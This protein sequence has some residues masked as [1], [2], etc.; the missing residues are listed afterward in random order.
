MIPAL[1]TVF[2]FA[3]SAVAGERTARYW[4]SQTG[5]LLRLGLATLI[6]GSL[7]LWLWPDS[8]DPA[9]YTWLFASGMIGFGFGD[10]A[11]FLA[12]VRIG[13]RLTILLNLC[14][15]PLWSTVVEGLWLGQV[16]GAL[17]LCAGAVIL[18]GVVMAVMSRQAD[19]HQRLGSP[20]V[21][22]ACGLLAGCGQGLGAVLSRKALDVA[23]DTGIVMNGMSAATQRVSGGLLTT[24][25]VFLVLRYLVRSP[26]A[27][28]VPASARVK[29]AW[30]LATTLCGPVL[31]V[32]C[33]QWAW[34][35]Q[36]AGVVTAVVATTPIA[37]IPLVMW[38][39]KEHPRPM[40]VAG[41]VIAVAGVLMLLKA[42][43]QW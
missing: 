41:A 34:A 17:E 13:A 27:P 10:I 31:G 38:A 16:P 28:V 20:I 23:A 30:L 36:T 39:D 19:S 25:L 5:N 6:L 3:G 22:V 8:L 26:A 18:G 32:S 4:G 14:T 21:G 33:F 12:Y 7:C 40:S 15:A 37:M 43:G 29:S 24:L 42:Q 1:L 35:G 11:L 9:T 2:L